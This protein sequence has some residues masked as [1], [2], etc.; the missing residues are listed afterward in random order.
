MRA[1]SAVMIDSYT[2]PPSAQNAME[3][4]RVGGDSE[5]WQPLQ[6][7][8][9]RF[10]LKG[11]GRRSAFPRR[12]ARP[13]GEVGF[14]VCFASGDWGDGDSLSNTKRPLGPHRETCSCQVCTGR[15]WRR[16]FPVRNAVASG[17]LSA[18]QAGEAETRVGGG[19]GGA[20]PQG[21]G[22]GYG[23]GMGLCT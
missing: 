9:M 13:A 11:P 20:T 19:S 4:D 1:G 17:A 16:F 2:R 7:M 3:R 22:T 14:L 21:G 15:D 6:P 12:V 5:E 18:S 8:T 10:G 23:A